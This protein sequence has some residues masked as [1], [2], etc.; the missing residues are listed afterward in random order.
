MGEQPVACMDC[1]WTGQHKHGPIR[2]AKCP[3]CGGSTIVR[4][5]T[6]GQTPRES[7]VP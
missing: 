2:G 1:G 7:L 6:T 5:D 4:H 3:N